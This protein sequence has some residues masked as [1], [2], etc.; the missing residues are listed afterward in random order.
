[1]ICPIFQILTF[2]IWSVALLIS[3]VQAGEISHAARYRSCMAMTAKNPAAAFS[4]A[5]QW[6]D[7]GG[8]EGADHCTA[9]ALIGLH[10]YREAATRLEEMAL[11]SK[12]APTMKASILS[13]AS[14]AWLLGGDIKRAEAVTTS[15]ITLAPNDA[16]LHIDR[17]AAR[18][19]LKDYQRAL[20]DLNISLKIGPGNADALVF[21]ATTKRFLKDIS[22]AAGD[23]ELAL[24][25]NNSHIEALLERGILRRL[26]NYDDGAREDW[27]MILS[28]AP[29]SEAANMARRNLEKMDVKTNQ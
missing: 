3:A 20:E 29:G 1:M 10:Q 28:I 5:I 26:S 27:L 8:G 16:E 7:L 2:S 13:Q 12:R 9:V 15:A 6:R 21:R 14:Q 4:D 23:I 11:K 24:R 17:A 22:G 18:A 19:L 25:L